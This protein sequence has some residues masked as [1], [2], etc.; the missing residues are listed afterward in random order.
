MQ[1]RGS[2]VTAPV[3]TFSVSGKASLN[4]RF[5]QSMTAGNER[6]LTD[7]VSGVNRMAP[8]PFCRGLQKESHLRLA[9]A[10]DRLHG[11]A[12]QEQCPSVVG[13]ASP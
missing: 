9:K 10:V 3:S 8:I 11:I 6:K 13:A 4:A 12:N 1:R 5:T 2:Y 7:S